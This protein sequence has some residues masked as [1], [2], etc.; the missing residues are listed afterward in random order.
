MDCLSR[1]ELVLAGIAAATIGAAPRDANEPTDR[2]LV[3]VELS[4]GNDGLD[5]LLPIGDDAYHRARPTLRRAARAALCIDEH[6]AFHPALL[7]CRRLWDEGRVAIVQGCG[8]ATL[9]RDHFAAIELWHGGIP[10]SGDFG[11]LGRLADATWPDA[12]PPLLSVGATPSP[13]LRSR[14]H[15]LVAFSDGERR[16]HGAASVAAAARVAMRD[17]RTPVDYGATPLGQDLRR[18]AALI[19]AG[20]P[21][22]VY[23]AAIGGFDTHAA[24]ADTRRALLTELDAAV[25]GF[26]R[27]LRRLDRD[28]QVAT[29]LFSE[30]GRRLEENASLGTDH[31]TSGIVLLL[32]AGVVPGLHGR[33]PSLT[34]LDANGDLETT[35]DFRRVYADVAG[36]WLGHGD[37]AALLGGR[38]EPLGLLRPR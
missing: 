3:A 38:F 9:R 2:I 18:V 36:E 30:F 19:G 32:G 26:Q 10:G 23:A 29:L 13:A 4:G 35:T 22:R 28:R 21:T 16:V 1:R 8:A 33:P 25:S 6:L 7:G 27:D 14:R 24:Q 12:P 20:F 15:A 17:Y 31:G 5:T 37:P 11:W 34:R